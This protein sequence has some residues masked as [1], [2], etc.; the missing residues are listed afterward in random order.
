MRK[1]TLVELIIAIAIIG[2]LISVL[3]PSLQNSRKAVKAAYCMSSMKQIGTAEFLSNKDN[4]NY[5]TIAF[6]TS[7]REVWDEVLS[8]YW[9]LPVPNVRV[10]NYTHD[11]YPDLLPKLQKFLLCPIDELAVLEN[12]P[13]RARRTYSMNGYGYNRN[14]NEVS[15]GVSSRD[16][17]IQVS[18]VEQP[19]MTFTH[20]EQPGPWNS[21]GGSGH[22]SALSIFGWQMTNAIVDELVFHKPSQVFNYHFAD[23]SVRALNVWKAWDGGQYGMWDRNKQ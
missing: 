8:K 10:D 7:T 3:L 2:V 4:S 1:F 6:N 11:D 9:G 21:I 22:S 13:G 23:G 20:L 15:R 5:C 18:E 17:T 14:T 19:S 16:A 12:W